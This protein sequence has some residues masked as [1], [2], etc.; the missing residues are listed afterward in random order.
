[1]QHTALEQ[2]ADPTTTLF[3]PGTAHDLRYPV[4][5]AQARARALP[6]PVA[7]VAGSDEL[8]IH[9]VAAAASE[10]FC[11]ALAL[12]ALFAF[13]SAPLLAHAATVDS[14][15][16]LFLGL[17]CLAAALVIQLSERRRAVIQLTQIGL[18]RG[19]TREAAQQQAR[20]ILKLWLS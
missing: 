4:S 9:P 12:S 2:I 18:G 6:K 7:A 20:A 5:T 19:L 17:C 15:A 13:G 1:M 11:G 3:A 8:A 14:P 10:R 16:L